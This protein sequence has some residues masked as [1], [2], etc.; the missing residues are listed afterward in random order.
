[1]NTKESLNYLIQKALDFGYTEQMITPFIFELKER[2]NSMPET[3]E[4]DL[5]KLFDEIF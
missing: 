1:M 2:L 3:D 5:N 4:E